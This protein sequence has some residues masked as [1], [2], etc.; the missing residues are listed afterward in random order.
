MMLYCMYIWCL[1]GWLWDV[2][3]RMVVSDFVCICVCEVMCVMLSDGDFVND[4]NVD[5]VVL[6]KCVEVIVNDDG[7]VLNLLVL[8]CVFDDEMFVSV[9]VMWESD[10]DVWMMVED[11]V[12]VEE[13]VFVEVLMW[14]KWEGV[15]AGG[16]AAMFE[17]ACWL[18]A[19]EL[20][21]WVEVWR[22]WVLSVV[23]C[24][25]GEVEVLEW[26]VYLWLLIYYLFG[27]G[28]TVERESAEK[29]IEVLCVM[30]RE[31][32][33]MRGDF[34][35]LLFCSWL[36]CVFW[37][38]EWDL[39]M[40]RLNRII[41]WL[42]VNSVLA[43]RRA[44]LDGMVYDGRFLWDECDWCVIV[45]VIDVLVKCDLDGN[46][47]LML[48]DSDGFMRTKS[49]LYSFN[50]DAEVWLCKWLWKFICVGSV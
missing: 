38:E 2:R 4:E 17:D 46:L 41:A 40:F 12:C 6:K 11:D 16:A 39:V 21:M 20:W 31:E 22:W 29:E 37:D 3:G 13:F 50:A 28:A 30:L 36:W 32:G 27:D 49:A 44:E 7:D 23:K 33:G 19:W 18:W 45:D 9:C 8:L 34:F 15:G 25:V 5:V 42:E 48:L 43:F 10:V 35:L 14:V 47:L 24:E 1:C 26:E